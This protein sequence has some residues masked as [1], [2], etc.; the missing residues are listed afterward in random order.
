M[1]GGRQVAARELMKKVFATAMG[2]VKGPKVKIGRVQ[3]P[4]NAFGFFLLGGLAVAATAGGALKGAPKE[5]PQSP[6]E[7]SVSVVSNGSGEGVQGWMYESRGEQ[8]E[9]LYEKEVSRVEKAFLENGVTKEDF[10]RWEQKLVETFSLEGKASVEK[11]TANKIRLYC[12][13]AAS[14]AKRGALTEG[15]FGNPLF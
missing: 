8:I 11:R 6:G 7:V 4:L 2:F 9:D 12:R 14:R 10:A 1:R 3:L 5:P 13:D 15:D